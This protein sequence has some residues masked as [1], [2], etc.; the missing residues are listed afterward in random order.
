[1]YQ[2]LID[3]QQTLIKKYRLIREMEETNCCDTDFWISAVQ[4]LWT[5]EKSFKEV[6]E[7]LKA[8]PRITML[9]YH[10]EKLEK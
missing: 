8:D 4:E 3:V 5:V 6:F 7:I 1:M 10:M 9:E 2:K